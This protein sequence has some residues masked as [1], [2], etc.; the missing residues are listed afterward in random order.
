M[1]ELAAERGGPQG[2]EVAV[3]L[4]SVSSPS[5]VA[6]SRR[7]VLRRAALAGGAIVTGGIVVAGLGDLASSAPSA[8]QDVRVLN[9]ALHLEYL[10]QALYEAAKDLDVRAPVSRYIE[11]VSGHEAEHVAALQAALGDEADAAP[12]FDFGSALQ[13][14]DGF[15]ATAI[16]VE[17][18]TVSAYNGQAAN[19][20]KKTLAAAAS[21]VSVDARH[22]GWIPGGRR[23]AR[24]AGAGRPGADGAAG[25]GRPH[26]ARGWRRERPRPHRRPVRAVRPRRR[27]RGGA[28]PR[29]PQHARGPAARHGGRRPRA[30]GPRRHAARRARSDRQRRGDPQLR[31]PARVPAGRLLHRGRAPRRDPRRRE[32]GAR[33]HRAGRAR[34]R[35][36][37]T[38]RCSG[39]PRASAPFYDFRGTTEDPDSFLRTAVAFEDLAAAAYKGQAPLI[40]APNVLAAAI[41][42]HSV[43][44]RHAAWIRFLAGATPA[45]DG[46]RQAPHASRR[47]SPW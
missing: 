38:R 19:L 10:Q 25:A 7:S 30:R 42:I 36:R 46:V 12:T 43:E 15:V 13:D 9:F 21:I 29:D 22:A 37:A 44:A 17:D 5:P 18:L 26:R 27:A 34:P 45:D 8:A 23:Q 3:E 41:A 2:M 11:V 16:A 1:A 24:R 28:R 6:T 4:V 40:D 33:R 35:P 20:R 39:R 47:C 32:G 14:E 31:A